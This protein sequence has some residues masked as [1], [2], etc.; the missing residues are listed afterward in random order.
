MHA[1]PLTA[2]LGAIAALALGSTAASAN[3][4]LVG[5]STDPFTN[6]TSQHATELEPDT[7]AFGNTVVAAY[8][9][10]RFFN[11]G[12]TDIGF[13]RSADGGATWDTSGVLPGTTFS[14]G[15][16]APYERVSDA[17]VAYDAKHGVW[18]ISSIPLLPNTSVPTVFV[19]RSTDDGVTFQNPVTIPPP[20]SN[21][22]DLDK[23]WSVCDNTAS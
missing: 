23:N 11:G 7:F 19:S 1:P 21:S 16:A 17:S 6:A 18:L 12:A 20:V 5:V 2:A 9:V 8:Q 14:A 3:V 15:F 10:G 22:I 13:V 4:P